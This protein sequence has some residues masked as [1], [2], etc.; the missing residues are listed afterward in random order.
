MSV[1]QL[2]DELA[3]LQ[4]IGFDNFQD[5][6]DGPERRKEYDLEEVDV[7]WKQ[8]ENI[9]MMVGDVEQSG[10]IE[11][12]LGTTQLPKAIPAVDS[13]DEDDF[14]TNLPPRSLFDKPLS[15]LDDLSLSPISADDSGIE[16]TPDTPLLP[17]VKILR[18][19]RLSRYQRIEKAIQFLRIGRI[20]PLMF[21]NNIFDSQDAHFETQKAWMFG[22][23]GKVQLVAI[24]DNIMR[25]ERGKDILLEWMEPYATKLVTQRISEGM[26][27][28]GNKIHTTTTKITPRDLREWTLD[29]AG[30][31]LRAENSALFDVLRAASRSSRSEKNS[32]K[33]TYNVSSSDDSR[34]LLQTCVQIG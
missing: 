23:K 13:D 19:G 15:P 26:D 2:E 31:L 33:K 21:L 9:E 8:D 7:Y 27:S 30:N 20:S 18:T 4:I 17:K 3:E 12:Y 10:E 28:L 5:L 29:H 16:I 25:D 6:R 24:L 14:F 11:T 1:G 32:K 34:R 22:E